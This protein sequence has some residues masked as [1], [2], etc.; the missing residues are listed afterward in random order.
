MAENAYI[1]L[2]I[3]LHFAWVRSVLGI[4]R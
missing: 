1:F 4:T 2:W 3:I